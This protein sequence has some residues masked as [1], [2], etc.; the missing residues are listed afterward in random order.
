M[1]D[2][3]IEGPKD[4]DINGSNDNHDLNEINL[5]EEDNTGRNRTQRNRQS[6]T[7]GLPSANN[8]SGLNRDYWRLLAP[9]IYPK[10]SAM[11][12]AEK[13]GIQMMTEYFE[14]EASKTTRIRRI[15]R[16]RIRIRIRRRRRR[17]E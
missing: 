1:N 3:N 7:S 2:Y 16:I 8:G 13:A 9:H 17:N 12:V 10:V 11:G 5:D 14:V 6:M 4:D 15:R